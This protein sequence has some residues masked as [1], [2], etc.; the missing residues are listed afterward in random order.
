MSYIKKLYGRTVIDC[1]DSI[2]FPKDDKI[3]LEYYQIKNETSSKPYGIEIVKKNIE[4]NV[5]NI[6]DKTVRHIC[7]KEQDNMRL[8]EILMIN[9]VTPIAVDDVIEDLSKTKEI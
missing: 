7:N 1:S 4:N 9:K 6:E 5:M 2:E 3:E 8:L